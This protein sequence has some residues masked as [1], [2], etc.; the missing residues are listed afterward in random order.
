[1]DRERPYQEQEI[2]G[3]VIY[4][5][6]P[7]SDRYRPISST[8]W[9]FQTNYNPQKARLAADGKMSTRWT[10]GSP[11][12][13]GAYF[14]IDFGHLEKVGPNSPFSGGFDQ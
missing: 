3:Q 6:T 9:R 2:S 11:Q 5:F 1:M 12:V 14:Q 8:R 7:S 10:T 13:P 4:F